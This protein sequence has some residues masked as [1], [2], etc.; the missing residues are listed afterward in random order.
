MLSAYIVTFIREIYLLFFLFK[1][2]TLFFLKIFLPQGSSIYSETAAA[3]YGDVDIFEM[4]KSRVP[5]KRLGTVEEISAAVCFMLSPAASFIT[6]ETL[7][8]DGGGKLY[9]MMWQVP[10]K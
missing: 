1:I 6:G 9:Q 4:V 8:V 5:M 2:L 10:G 3:N 7:Y